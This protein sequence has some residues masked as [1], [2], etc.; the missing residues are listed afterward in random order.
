MYIPEG[1][2]VPQ[3]SLVMRFLC[4]LHQIVLRG[5]EELRM[6]GFVGGLAP[7]EAELLGFLKG[8]PALKRVITTD[9]NEA[10]LLSVLD[11]LGCQAIVVK[12]EE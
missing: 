5:V 3:A 8:M 6:D 11:S 7:Q 4:E 10:Q 1:R 12:V 2:T 9:G